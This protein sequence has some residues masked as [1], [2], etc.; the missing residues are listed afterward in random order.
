MSLEKQIKSDSKFGDIVFKDGRL[1]ITPN[2]DNKRH[3]N[4]NNKY[5]GM[6]DNEIGRTLKYL[7]ENKERQVTANDIAER[8]GIELWQAK[9]NLGYV[10]AIV[11]TVSKS[12][13]IIA[14]ENDGQTTYQ[15][16][17]IQ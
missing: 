15:M 16:Q 11:N 17:G 9:Q 7:L 12:Y 4:Y 6:A 14:S 13:N 10:K 2:G 1:N 5:S 8:L 3:T